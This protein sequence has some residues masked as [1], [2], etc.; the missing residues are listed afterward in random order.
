MSLR[1]W[2]N[3]IDG[4]DEMRYPLI[5]AAGGGDDGGGDA[6][7]QRADALKALHGRRK[8]A[9]RCGVLGGVVSFSA[10]VV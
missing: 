1:N 5:R 9:R 8:A 4:D 2:W 10:S 7:R 6:A 3:G